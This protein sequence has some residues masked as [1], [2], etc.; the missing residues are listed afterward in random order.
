MIP[1]KQVRV[2]ILKEKDRPGFRLQCNQIFQE[3]FCGDAS[4]FEQW[5]QSLRKCS[6]FRD[7]NSHYTISKAIGKGTFAIVYQAT[8]SGESKEYAVKSFDKKKIG[9]DEKTKVRIFFLALS[10]H[11]LALT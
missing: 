3:V 5:H 8:R 11:I 9:S 1:L 10:P 2:E 4:K 6:V 7:F